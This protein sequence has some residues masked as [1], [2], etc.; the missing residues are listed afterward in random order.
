MIFCCG[1]EPQFLYLMDTRVEAACHKN[2][3]IGGRVCVLQ[4]T[5]TPHPNHFN[6]EYYRLLK[7]EKMA[8]KQK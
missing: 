8:W 4:G 2:D 5:W 1:G 3:V 6:N 7:S